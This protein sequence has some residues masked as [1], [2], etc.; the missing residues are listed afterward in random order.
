MERYKHFISHKQ[1]TKIPS[2][3]VNNGKTLIDPKCIASAIN[4]YFVNVAPELL[5]TLP[6]STSGKSFNHFLK[7]SNSNSLFL[8]P[9]SPQ[10]IKQLLDSL[11]P[12]KATDIYNFPIKIIKQCSGVLDEPLAIIIK[13]LYQVEPFPINKN[14]L[15][16][17]HYSKAVLS[18]K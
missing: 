7:R 3:I 5:K 10:D 15:R 16:L 9:V 17:F 2:V 12:K 11:D 1:S 14:M 13:S 6:K 4:S 18:M 8:Q